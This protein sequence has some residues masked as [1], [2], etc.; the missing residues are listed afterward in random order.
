MEAL[1]PELQQALLEL[2]AAHEQ[3]QAQQ[4][5]QQHQGA[6][7]TDWMLGEYADAVGGAFLF[8]DADSEDGQQQ[9]GA[10]RRGYMDGGSKRTSSTSSSSQRA[11]TPAAQAAADAG[12][13]A[14]PPARLTSNQLRRL[15]QQYSSNAPRHPLLLQA[16]LAASLSPNLAFA[17]LAGRGNKVAEMVDKQA[18]A[19]SQWAQERA[20]GGQAGRDDAPASAAAASAQAAAAAAAAAGDKAAQQLVREDEKLSAILLSRCRKMVSC[21]TAVG[22]EAFFNRNSLLARRVPQFRCGSCCACVAAAAADVP[23]HASMM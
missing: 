17:K 8:S 11:D 10:D 13:L 18:Q 22:G 7:A 19:V 9:L 5:V 21:T 6:A 4:G 23:D 12:S 2:Q 14:Q 1:E 20:G 15:I 16:A 3:A